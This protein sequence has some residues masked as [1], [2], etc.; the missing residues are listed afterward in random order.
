VCRRAAVALVLALSAPLL[1]LQTAP[2][3]AAFAGT[4]ANGS[5]SMTAAA[6]FYRAF[7]VADGPVSYWRLGEASGTTAVDV[8]GTRNGA[9]AGTY[10]LGASGALI[11]DPD[12]A[13]DLDGVSGRVTVPHVAAYNITAA[14]TI[15]AWMRPDAIT[16]TRW[17]M[18]KGTYYYMYILNSTIVFGVHTPAGYLFLQSTNITVGAWQHF[19][20]TYNGTTLVLYRNGVNITQAAATGAIDQTAVA[21]EIGSNNGASNFFDGKLDEVALYNKALTAA[22]ALAH[23]QRGALTHP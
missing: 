22:Q 7:I 10:T 8:M 20:G 11:A 12:T 16:L 1:A 23:Y 6:S 14:I 4:T 5:N 17:I 18:N 19:V 9:Y 13:V 15:E 2:T 3:W 21:L